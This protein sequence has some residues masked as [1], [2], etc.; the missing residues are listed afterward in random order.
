MAE[1]Q[2]ARMQFY[3]PDVCFFLSKIPSLPPSLEA[4]DEESI[5]KLHEE[6]LNPDENAAHLEG[7]IEFELIVFLVDFKK[8]ELTTI[9]MGKQGDDVW[10]NVRESL[11]ANA[12]GHHDVRNRT[13]NLLLWN[14]LNE[15]LRE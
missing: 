13:M 14:L 6:L 4:H 15:A 7:I 12:G 3:T 5:F 11:E 2:K 9:Q 8:Q 10:V 1:G